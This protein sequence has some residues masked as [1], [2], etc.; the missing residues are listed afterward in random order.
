MATESTA[1]LDSSLAGEAPPK[2]VAGNKVLTD[3]LTLQHE[4]SQRIECRSPTTGWI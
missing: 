2:K 1:Q 4:A 3:Q